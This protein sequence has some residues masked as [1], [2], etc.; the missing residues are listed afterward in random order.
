MANYEIWSI[1]WDGNRPQRV[2]MV[3]STPIRDEALL[4]GAEEHRETGQEI[5]L[6]LYRADEGIWIPLDEYWG[7]GP[8]DREEYAETIKHAADA[9][10][11]AMQAERRLR[12]IDKRYIAG[13]TLSGRIVKLDKMYA[14]ATDFE[15][16]YP[17]RRVN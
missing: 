7:D 4:I 9:M 10:R 3:D 13:H 17:P 14:Q 11:L 8:F 12:S 6:Y 15:Q 16:S 5:G 2:S 1:T